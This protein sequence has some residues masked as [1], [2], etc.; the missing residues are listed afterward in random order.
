M[1]VCL[2][3]QQQP[4]RPD[5]DYL[6]ISQR[7]IGNTLPK[8]M[9]IDPRLAA[10]AFR[11]ACGLSSSYGTASGSERVVSKSFFQRATTRSLPLAVP[12]DISK[13]RAETLAERRRWIGNNVSLAYNDPVK[14]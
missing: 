9:A 12:K 2:A 6:S 5:D 8:L 1:S 13:T 11:D 3:A 10:S 7:S 4:Q 14:I